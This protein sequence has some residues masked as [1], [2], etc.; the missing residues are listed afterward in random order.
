MVSWA[1]PGKVAATEETQGYEVCYCAGPC[2][3]ESHWTKVPGVFEVEGTETGFT[4]T[5]AE[6]TRYVEF[7]LEVAGATTDHTI[8]LAKSQGRG[9]AHLEAACKAPLLLNATSAT[10]GSYTFGP[11]EDVSFPE[12][13]PFG[14]YV[15]CMFD[16]AKFDFAPV[17]GAAGPFLT[18][19]PE[20]PTD[21]VTVAGFFKEQQFSVMKDVPVSLAILGSQLATAGKAG[22]ALSKASTCSEALSTQIADWDHK[23]WVKD[24]VGFAETGSA[25]DSSTY[26][27]TV[28]AD[29]GTYTICMCD[30]SAVAGAVDNDP[31]WRQPTKAYLKYYGVTLGHALHMTIAG[32]TENQSKSEAGLKNN[33]A[34]KAIIDGIHGTTYPTVGTSDEAYY[35]FIKAFEES[36]DTFGE[37]ADSIYNES[38]GM[39]AEELIAQY[40]IS[41][42]DLFWL[43][44]IATIPGTP[45]ASI[46]EDYN[47]SAEFTSNFK[48][49]DTGPEPEGETRVT[50]IEMKVPMPTEADNSKMGFTVVAQATECGPEKCKGWELVTPEWYH[51]E[52]LPYDSWGDLFDTAEELK[53]VWP[54]ASSECNAAVKYSVTVG[55]LV[56][57]SRTDLGLTYVLEPGGEQSI[58]ITGSGLKPWADRMTFVNCQDTCGV[59]KPSSLVGFP[60]GDYIGAFSSFEPVRDLSESPVDNCPYVN[61][62]QN[63][64]LVDTQFEKVKARY[65]H[66]ASVDLSMLS[67]DKSALVTRQSCETKCTQ[68]CDGKHCYC[69]GN[70]GLDEAFVE[71]AVCLPKYECEHLCMM[72][73]DA[74]HSVT[75]HETLPRCFLNGPACVDQVDADDPGVVASVI[76]AIAAAAQQSSSG[77]KGKGGAAAYDPPALRPLGLNLDYSLYVKVGSGAV[78][79][80]PKGAMDDEF[81]SILWSSSSRGNLVQGSGFST[82]EVLR[83]AP[84]TLPSAGTYKVCFCDSEV[85]GGCSTAE[86]FSVEV[87]KVHVSGL[88]CLLS[89]P[90]LQTAKCF[91]QYFGGMRCVSGR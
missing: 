22:I 13:M 32:V 79:L 49:V 61:Y 25:S 64:F 19:V 38:L 16:F 71:S 66:N 15:V 91:E 29:P 6:P 80:D 5:P 8:A 76:S 56:V 72:L 81:E 46:I 34:L 54:V 63:P 62:T 67:P 26:D 11:L 87:G 10:N 30:G 58:E 74:C 70:I 21:A 36:G 86:D 84:L 59:S 65:C 57:T 27:I 52:D 68:P 88:S 77:K 55:K 78:P 35:V 37:I 12:V 7:T 90:K 18:I 33:M 23:I 24:N 69:E 4:V 2:F 73:G 75:A 48:V 44:H 51:I 42:S 39:F 28:T 60:D 43:A 47:M 9:L 20:F 45:N 40:S 1:I 17:P 82:Q 31:T 41:N 3:A 50:T 53:V 14:D 89:V 83:F 85:S